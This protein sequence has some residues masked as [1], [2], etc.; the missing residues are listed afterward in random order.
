MTERR[1]FAITA[2]LLFCV[3]MSVVTHTRQTIHES[4]ESAR[5][6]P[7]PTQRSLLPDRS[8]PRSSVDCGDVCRYDVR[9]TPGK[10]FPVVEKH[11]DCTSIMLR[12]Y[13][14]KPATQWPPPTAPAP[15]DMAAFTQNGL[16]PIREQLYFAQ[17]YAGG[18]AMENTWTQKMVD[19]L[20]KKARRGEQIGWYGIG[21]EN[22]IRH[23]MRNHPVTG[24]KGAVLGSEAPWLEA[25][26]LDAGAAHITTIEY[27]K[28]NSQHPLISTAIPSDI[29]T[30]YLRGELEP[31][32]FISTH[33][34]L[35]H[36]GLG[37]Y[38][39][40]MNAYGDLEAAAQA[41]CL[42]KPGGLFFLGLPVGTSSYMRFN[43]D[44]NYGPDR[45]KHMAAGFEQLAHYGDWGWQ[46]VFVLRKPVDAED[47]NRVLFA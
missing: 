22:H 3:V 17:R 7:S 36:S 1:R 19:E 10:L 14:E 33:S 28:I 42:L 30:R 21:D 31:F 13:L 6:V 29:A 41:W 44:R 32:D 8:M 2:A 38:G 37:R 16:M 18:D 5:S 24:L 27:G 23:S 45:M 9:E 11:I 43:A 4:A 15:E 20:Q 12:S 40:A 34:S 25:L 47:G 26:V 46:A 39:D 35:E